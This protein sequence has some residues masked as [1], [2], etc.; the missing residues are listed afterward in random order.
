[1][2]PFDGE[3]AQPHG[4]LVVGGILSYKLQMSSVVDS[5]RRAAGRSAGGRMNIGGERS[6]E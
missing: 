3:P 2:S 6:K 1:M 5:E 4:S